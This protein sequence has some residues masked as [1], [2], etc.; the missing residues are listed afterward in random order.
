MTANFN[1]GDVMTRSCVI[2]VLAVCAFSLAAS[3]Q[4]M[5]RGGIRP[6]GMKN[7]ICPSQMMVKFSTAN[8]NALVGTG[9]TA[10]EA[11][12][13]V[14]LDMSNPPHISGGNMVCYYRLGGQ[15][16]AFM[17]YQTIGNRQCSVLSNGTGFTCTM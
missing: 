8:P 13:H 14:Q 15:P 2:A 11:G 1:Q 9:W 10:N 16:A 3:A 6:A 17:I 12:F 5:N 4:P 7:F